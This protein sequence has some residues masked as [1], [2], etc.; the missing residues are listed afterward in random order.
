MNILDFL[1]EKYKKGGITKSN[2]PW[3]IFSDPFRMFCSFVG[4]T[5]NIFG[6]MVLNLYWISKNWQSHERLQIVSKK[7]ISLQAG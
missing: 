3:L 7:E 4:N 1:K 5:E 2:L 6:L